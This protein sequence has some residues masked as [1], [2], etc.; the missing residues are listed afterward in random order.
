MGPGAPC[1]SM[2]TIVDDQ[3]I[4][5]RR[6]IFGPVGE[7]MTTLALRGPI[8]LL[9]TPRSLRAI[10]D[11]AFGGAEVYR[12]EGVR[13]HNPRETVDEA[14]ALVDAR[15]CATVVAIG[16]SSAIDLGKAVADGR[17]V[18]LVLVPTALGGAEMSRGY[19]VREGDRK[20]GGRLASPAPIVVYD[21]ELL[22]TLPS[23]ELGSIGI[24]AWAHTIEAAYARTP[25]ALGGAAA[26]A[27]GRALPGLLKR[28]S[29][30]RDA[31]LHRELFEA[32]HLAGFALDTRSMGL[33]HAICHVIGGLTGIPHG[34]VNAVVLPHAIR[35]NARLAPEAVAAV[36]EAFG[37]A[38][39]AAE[40]DAIAKAYG[41]PRT[42]RELGGPSD[43]VARTVPRVLEQRLLDNN[44]V[45]PDEAAV[46][47]A[48]RGAYG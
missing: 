37:I 36:S 11:A 14:G 3:R 33:H 8:A 2:R 24:N 20:A 42:F 48:V 28:A 5:E 17:D 46:E 18:K 21:A 23:R 47:A 31:A 22:A 40:A 32:A 4:A 27:A 43:L 34:I 19:G 16:S 10:D 7:A 29:A 45:R 12:Y 6:I 13:L 30:S 1:G 26:I 15:G 39:L 38:D 25:H 44:P 41:L 9:G 35:A